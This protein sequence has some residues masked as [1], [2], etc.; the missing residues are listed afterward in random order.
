MI[1]ER[2]SSGFGH[3]ADWTNRDFRKTDPIEWN[4]TTVVGACFYQEAPY[5]ATGIPDPRKDIFPRSMKDV[6]FRFCNLDNVIV[7]PGNI[8]EA[9]CCHRRIRVQN[10]RDDW[11]LNEDGQP[12]KPV[13][14]KTRER[15]GV[16]IDPAD[17]PERLVSEAEY[18][19]LKRR[20]REGSQNLTEVIYDG[21]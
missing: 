3:D 17:L 12:L 19:E 10:D 20:L 1:N 15:Q 2:Y 7:P 5:S 21:A 11:A 6:T 4:G 14:K 13:N 18:R 16:T 9:N 8:V